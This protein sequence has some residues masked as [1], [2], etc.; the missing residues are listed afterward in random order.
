MTTGDIDNDGYVKIMLLEHG[1]GVGGSGDTTK[2]VLKYGDN[3][4]REMELPFDFESDIDRGIQIETTMGNEPDTY[5]VYC[6]MLDEIITFEAENSMPDYLKD[7]PLVA[8][9]QCRGIMICS[10]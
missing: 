8:G 9:A 6:P 4:I 3:W 2:I 10:V 1:T 7:V 5:S